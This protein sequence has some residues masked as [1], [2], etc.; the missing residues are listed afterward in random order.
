MKMF[1]IEHINNFKVKRGLNLIFGTSGRK[2]GFKPFWMGNFEE[3]FVHGFYL[4]KEIQERLPELPDDLSTRNEIMR[5]IR[6][7]DI[8]FMPHPT[9]PDKWFAVHN[10]DKKA[11]VFFHKEDFN[12]VFPITKPIEIVEKDCP[13][14]H[15]LSYN[16]G[17]RTECHLCGAKGI[18][19]P[20][21][22]KIFFSLADKYGIEI[23]NGEGSTNDF[24]HVND[25]KVKVF[26]TGCTSG[27]ALSKTAE[28]KY[29]GYPSF[30]LVPGENALIGATIGNDL[31][32]LKL[33][34]DGV[35]L[36]TKVEKKFEHIT[37]DFLYEIESENARYSLE[38]LI[39]SRKSSD[40]FATTTTT[41]EVED[42]PFAALKGLKFDN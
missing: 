36:S 23:G 9:I 14:N 15:H 21:D 20:S 3:E 42:S 34:F 16:Y 40:I 41:Q 29:D 37:L 35:D 25:G 12:I 6:V 5:N 2:K 31:Y 13:H 18:A 33:S 4:S 26:T 1:V 30:E 24:L 11:I 22:D 10:E 8:S 7:D 38:R 28:T 39:K 17:I 19:R 27:Y 32:V